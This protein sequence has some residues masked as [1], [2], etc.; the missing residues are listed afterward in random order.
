MVTRAW[1]MIVLIAITL[2][3][4]GY[5]PNVISGVG[6]SPCDPSITSVS[7]GSAFVGEIITI[8]GVCLEGVLEDALS[9]GDVQLNIVSKSDTELQG[10]VVAFSPV[11]EVSVSAADTKATASFEIRNWLEPKPEDIVPGRVIVE[12]AAGADPDSVFATVGAA[13]AQQILPSSGF[14]E[15]DRWWSMEIAGDEIAAARELAADEDV[16]WAQPATESDMRVATPPND[17]CYATPT[18]QNCDEAP[19]YGGLTGLPPMGADGQWGVQRIAAEGAWEITTGD[20]SVR[21]GVMDTGLDP[22]E[23]IDGAY[24]F[25]YTGDA[26]AYTLGRRCQ[27]RRALRWSRRTSLRPGMGCGC[28]RGCALARHIHREYELRWPSALQRIGTG[29]NQHGPYAGCGD[30][31]GCGQQRLGLGRP[32]HRSP[33]LWTLPCRI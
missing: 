17:P 21:V 28:L 25:D 19:Y 13:N 32:N 16:I 8:K 29:R 27:Q 15:L 31:S 24:Y 1:P 30:G 10:R 23:D 33:R 3:G 20:P 5:S 9:V 11:R 26:D 4:L 22:H 7:P 2:L 14:P 6:Q 18:T 12:L